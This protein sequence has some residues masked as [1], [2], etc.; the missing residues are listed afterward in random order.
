MFQKVGQCLIPKLDRNKRILQ[1]N[2]THEYRC[3]NSFKNIILNLGNATIL[4]HRD[5]MGS[6]S[7]MSGLFNI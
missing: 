4:T 7:V 1:S 3:N 2:L 5:S 6:S